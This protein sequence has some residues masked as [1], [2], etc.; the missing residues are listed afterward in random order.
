MPRPRKS[1]LSRFFDL[2][3]FVAAAL[4]ACFYLFV[5]SARMKNSMLAHYTAEHG[6]EYVVVAFFIWGLTDVAFRLLSFPREMVALR[7]QWLPRRAGKQPVYY[8]GVMLADLQ[9]KPA[10]MQQS[11]VGQ[12][13]IQALT[14]L[15]EKES[16]D[17]FPDY[18]HNLTDQAYE[19]TQTNYGLIKFICW[20]TPMFGFLG[21]VVHFGTA[22]GGQEAGDIADKLP[23]VVA[24]MGTAFNTTTVALIA[25]TTMMFCLFIC[26]RTERSIVRSID[27][28]V[29]QELLNRFEVVDAR[30]T[31]F[32]AAVET[33]NQA[34][35]RALEETVGRQLEA[36]EKHQ[37]WQSQL[38][39]EALEQF[40]RRCEANDTQRD[41]RLAKVLGGLETFGQQQ[42]RAA[43][44]TV[45]QIADVKADVSRLINELGAIFQ[46]ESELIRLQAT[47]SENLRLIEQ[48]QHFDQALHGLTAAVHLLTARH[49]GKDLRAA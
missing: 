10:W 22:L 16:A 38:W 33:G 15:T 34:T 42:H 45:A 1:L 21:T 17:G 12:R 8:A 32:L 30:M 19:N 4:T 9:K 18:L 26:E 35:M 23:T 25:A 47:L 37:Q 24:E 14:Y 48:S 40:E 31:P 20:V 41:A 27:D 6:M 29:E 3:L 44:T 7:Q 11:W 2:P 36:W 49:P 43:E 13:L 5:T 46:G 39:I 28:Y